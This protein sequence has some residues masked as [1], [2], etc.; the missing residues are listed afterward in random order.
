MVFYALANG[1]FYS[2]MFKCMS[3]YFTNNEK[4]ICSIAWLGFINGFIKVYTGKNIIYF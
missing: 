3:T 1:C 2:I 4:I